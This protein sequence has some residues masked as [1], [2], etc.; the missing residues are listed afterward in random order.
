MC[1][2]D[3]IPVIYSYSGIFNC[4]HLAKYSVQKSINTIMISGIKIYNLDRYIEKFKI[5]NTE[6]ITR[7]NRFYGKCYNDLKPKKKMYENMEEFR[8]RVDREYT[9]KEGNFILIR[10]LKYKSSRYRCVFKLFYCISH[11]QYHFGY[12]AWRNHNPEKDRYL[13]SLDLSNFLFYQQSLDIA[14]VRKEMAESLNLIHHNF[15]RIDICLDTNYDVIRMFNRMYSDSRKYYFK[16]FGRTNKPVD[17]YGNRKREI[18]TGEGHKFESPT[19]RESFKIYNK[20][21]EIENKSRKFYIID[22]L[23]K[24]GIDISSPIFR[25]EVSLSSFSFKKRDFVNID[26]NNLTD[27]AVLKKIFNEY[28]RL[29]L[30][31]RLKN[32]Q[33]NVSRYKKIRLV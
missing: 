22:Y 8:N 20:T 32:N 17:D 16:S 9:F 33:K 2:F 26:E 30:D 29:C 6:H 15:E 18:S 7:F 23:E 19:Y 14:A 5:E 3:L 10:D 11:S 31:F 13:I 25:I 12:L 24:E 4:R 21:K 28:I 1:F 27:N